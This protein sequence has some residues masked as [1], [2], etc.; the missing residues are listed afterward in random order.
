M[1]LPFEPETD[2]ERR[3]TADP[4]WRE[5]AAWGKPRPGHRE[6]AVVNHIADVL[7]NI[8]EDGATGRDRERLRL[9]ALVHDVL[10]REQKRWLPPRGANH[11][12]RRARRFAEG[13]IDD[14]AVL[15]VIE[16]H[17]DAYHAWCAGE[18]SGRWDTAE[19]KAR[20]LVER[21]GDRLP[22]FLAFYRA[23]NETDSK[24]QE[25]LRWFERVAR[26]GQAPE[27]S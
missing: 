21:L 14:P 10:K 7:R 6:G 13:H 23:D 26:Q 5:G 25:P 18:R 24:T 9:I 19:H 3:I 4:R 20:A 11:H 22:L 1:R 2:L 16:L 12:A 8:D 17:D 27:R 15:D